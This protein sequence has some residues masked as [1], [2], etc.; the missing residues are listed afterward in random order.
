MSV[1]FE[2]ISDK[3]KAIIKGWKWITG[4]KS[5]KPWRIH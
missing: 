1:N 2:L 3:W 5:P 4:E